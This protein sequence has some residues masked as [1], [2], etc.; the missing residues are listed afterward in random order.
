[1]KATLVSPRLV[2][3]EGA[4]FQGDCEMTPTS[5]AGAGR[6]TVVALSGP[7]AAANGDTKS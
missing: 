7:R 5:A 2:I 3:E 1:V 4:F 6:A